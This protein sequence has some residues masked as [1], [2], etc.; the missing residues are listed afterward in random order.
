MD[1]ERSNENSECWRMKTKQRGPE[2][3]IVKARKRTRA[4][5]KIW[6]KGVKRR[7]DEAGQRAGTRTRANRRSKTEE[8]KVVKA[9][10]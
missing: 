2:R 6:Q 3:I 10:I 5:T 4:G 9:R 1:E 7:V 8:R